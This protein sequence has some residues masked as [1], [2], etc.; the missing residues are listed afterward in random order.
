MVDD[1]AILRGLL[2][3]VFSDAGYEVVEAEDGEQAIHQASRLNGFLAL[4]VTDITMPVMDGLEL[5]RRLRPL[6]PTVPIL[7]ITGKGSY[8]TT[9]VGSLE[10]WGALLRKPFSPDLLLEA[11]TRLLARGVHAGRTST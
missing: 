4:L 10:G 6:H 2:R 1:E 5:V 7:F 11:A 3:R 8:D 9:F